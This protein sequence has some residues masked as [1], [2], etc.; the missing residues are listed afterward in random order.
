MHAQQKK[1]GWF[2]NK[3]IIDEI[4]S[5]PED[6][7][8]YEE[9]EQRSS[10][11]QPN[12][13][14]EELTK[15]KREIV[16]KDEIIEQI[17]KDNSLEKQRLIRENEKYKQSILRTGE[18]K[19]DSRRQIQNLEAEVRQSRQEIQ[20]LTE[21]SE[22]GDLKIQLE[23]ANGE[24]KALNDSLKNYQDLESELKEAKQQYHE[25]ILSQKEEELHRYEKI[26]TLEVQISNLTIDLNK[27]ED[28]ITQLDQSILNKD[29]MIR[30]KEEHVRRLIED[31]NQQN[32]VIEGELVTELQHQI[33]TLQKEND[34][35]K[36]ESIHSQHEIGEV[37]IS[38]RKQ[39]NRMVEKAKMDAQRIIQDSENELQIIQE[40]AKEVSYE[41][42][43]S[44][45][46][47]L[48]IYDELK[49]RVDHLA[50]ND[51]PDLGEIKKQYD[52]PKA[53]GLA[54]KNY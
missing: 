15:L 25:L 50:H 8:M 49:N 36:Q 48:G 26:Q 41:V 9:Q 7:V 54:R 34:Q 16:E 24:V 23:K 30:E 13:Q 40:R 53:S 44:R 52:Y 37:L 1:N 29:Q 51:V 5:V 43:E 31:Q 4:N 22:S 46:A 47:I 2:F 14:S 6:R 45:Q 21:N 12:K 20:R 42:D 33:M 35:V 39:A 32:A 17:K 3:N 28:L 38:A 18:E 19:A 10:E 11:P 27:K